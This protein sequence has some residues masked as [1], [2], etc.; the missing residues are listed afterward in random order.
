V[1]ALAYRRGDQAAPLREEEGELR[2]LKIGAANI[3]RRTLAGLCLIAAPLVGLIGALLTPR[4]TGGFGDE[5]AAISEYPER[6]LIS[7]FLTLLSFFL[8]IPAVLGIVHLLRE[9]AVVLGH[10]GAGLVLLGLYFHAAVIGYSLVEVPLT[11]SGIE[12][13]RTIAFTEQMYNNAAFTMVLLPF[14]SFYLGSIILAVALWRA[15]VAPLWIA[16]VIVLALLTEFFGPEALSPALMFLLLLVGFGWVGLKVLRMA[17]AEWGQ[18]K[19][20]GGEPQ[21]RVR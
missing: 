19:E 12:R 9:R 5:L 14:L 7:T 13:A 20:G 16:F 15:R 10:I 2:M 3:S 8:L 6:W 11:A 4:F 17:D 18:V 1:V 21:P